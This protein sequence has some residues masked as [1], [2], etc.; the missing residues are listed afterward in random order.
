MT[1]LQSLE[2]QLQNYL[3][4]DDAA[5]F[6]HVVSTDNVS[7]DVRLGIYRNAYRMRLLEVL[8]TSYPVLQKYIGETEFE[9]LAFGFIDANPSHYRSIRWYGAELWQFIRAQSRYEEYPY[10]AELALLEWT[11]AL[12]F[13]GADSDVL[14]ISAMAT[15][16]PEKWGDLRF[17]LHPAIQRLTLEWNVVAIW[18][19]ITDDATPPE[20]L[21]SAKA[22]RWIV[23][24]NQ[25]MTQFA[26]LGDDE[27]Y[28]LD[29]ITKNITFGEICENLCQWVA[30]EQAGMHAAS[31]LKSWIIAGLITN[32][33]F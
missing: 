24:R 26:S 13:D 18:G 7:K 2:N 30:E 3:L 5:I 11:L 23:W 33:I 27:A 14:D 29:A 12:V 32:F 16:P 8:A 28:A 9:T 10:L 6:D 4:S 31:L 15:V 22:V 21:Q 20:P 25:Y 17:T 19:A 1:S